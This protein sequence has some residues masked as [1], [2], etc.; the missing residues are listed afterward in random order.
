MTGPTVAALRRKTCGCV[1]VVSMHK[2]LGGRASDEYR[3]VAL[4]A[5][6]ARVVVCKHNNVTTKETEK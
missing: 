1:V 5:D 6:E 4:P 3:P 2:R